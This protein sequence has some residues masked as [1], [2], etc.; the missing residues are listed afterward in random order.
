MKCRNVEKP[1]V[2]WRFPRGSHPPVQETPARSMSLDADGV[3]QLRGVDQPAQ[4]TQVLATTMMGRRQ[5]QKNDA[6]AVHCELHLNAL[7]ELGI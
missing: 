7:M 5:P 4:V 6:P 1:G 3:R 2:P